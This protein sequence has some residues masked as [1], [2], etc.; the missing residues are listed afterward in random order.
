MWIALCAWVRF[1]CKLWLQT[2][3]T[4][5]KREVANIY[6]RERE[7]ERV[8]T[9]SRTKKSKR[10]EN[11]NIEYVHKI[12]VR[13]LESNSIRIHETYEKYCIEKS[14]IVKHRTIERKKEQY[15]SCS[16]TW[17]ERGKAKKNETNFDQVRTYSPNKREILDSVIWIKKKI[18][19][20]IERKSRSARS[21]Q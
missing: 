7:R 16:S 6:E 20:K 11:T 3:T 2:I 1:Y 15:S 4:R 9:N 10:C 19:N 13:Y 5:T 8:W 21:T 18:D 17:I 14:A 12:S